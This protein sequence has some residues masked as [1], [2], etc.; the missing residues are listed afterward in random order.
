MNYFDESTL[1][2]YESGIHKHQGRAKVAGVTPPLG[3]STTVN[4]S[5]VGEMEDPCGVIDE[6]K[7]P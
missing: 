3:S 1:H 5:K 4:Q 6:D 2:G 7:V